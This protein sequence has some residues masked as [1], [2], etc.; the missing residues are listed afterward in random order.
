[1]RSAIINR[2]TKETDIFLSLNLD[3]TGKSNINT[4][5]GFLNHMLT[6]FASHGRFD[7]DVICKGDIDVDFHHSAE[8]IG[9]CLGQAFEQALGSKKGIYRYGSF[10]LPMD[11]TLILTAVDISGR[12]C[13]CYDLDIPTQK[14]GS[15]DTELVEEFFYAFVRNCQMSLHIRKL[16]G[17]N[18]HHIVEGAFKSVARSL[19]AAVAINPETKDEIPSTKGVL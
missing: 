9:I 4:G 15:F 8:D 17:K 14:I 11:E 1:M 6:L 10:I 12:C 7:L 16:D 18:S 3:G 2:K 13:L 19:K 5:C